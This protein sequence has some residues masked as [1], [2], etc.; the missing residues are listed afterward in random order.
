MERAELQTITEEVAGHLGKPWK[1]KPA[2]EHPW[3]GRIVDGEAKIILSSSSGRIT[4]RGAYPHGYLGW[5]RELPSITMAISRGAEVLAK[6][7]ERR[8]LPKYLPLFDESVEAR[9]ISNDRLEKEQIVRDAIVA[10]VNGRVQAGG[11][12]DFAGPGGSRG[13]IEVY[14]GTITLELRGMS[15]KAAILLANHIATL[16]STKPKER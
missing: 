7:I 11:K 16:K 13:N 5:G 10:E 6:E 12:I 1:Y 8:F 4:V 14:G 2:G 9:R 15:H 3:S